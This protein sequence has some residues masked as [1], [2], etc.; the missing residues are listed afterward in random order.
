MRS[1]SNLY[2]I[3][4]IFLI[5]YIKYYFE[6]FNRFIETAYMDIWIYVQNIVMLRSK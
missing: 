5:N 2:D 3:R 1:G 6:L 4:L